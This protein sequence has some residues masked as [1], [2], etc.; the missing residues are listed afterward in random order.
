MGTKSQLLIILMCGCG[1]VS[2]QPDAAVTPDSSSDD[3][4]TDAP[5]AIPWRAPTL[6]PG[7]SVTNF[8]DSVPTLRDDLCEMYFASD[9]DGNQDIYVSKR[10]VATDP[11]GPPVPVPEL[12][13]P[14]NTDSGPEISADG[15]TFWL[16]RNTSANG[17]EIMVASRT[18]LTAPWSTPTV[19]PE[20]SSTL[21]ERAPQITSDGRTM[22]FIRDTGL[23]ATKEIWAATWTPASSSW[24]NLR[25]VNA[26]NSPS[27]EENPTTT[28]DGLEIYF[29]STRDDV[30]N[31]SYLV[32]RS[33]KPMGGGPFGDP[34]AVPELTGAVST[35]VSPDGHYMVMAKN[36][37]D[38]RSDLYESFRP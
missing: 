20:L 8:G 25:E 24:T 15:R 1:E 35:E 30:A 16:A 7:L 6:I 22:Y 36:G 29:D 38:G 34:V 4:S 18:S 37:S 23:N 21:D 12:S 17:F 32:Y 26:L 5:A 33:T 27:N 28:G 31:A 19:I 14:T 3:A 2:G 9:R 13:S 10:N 11:W